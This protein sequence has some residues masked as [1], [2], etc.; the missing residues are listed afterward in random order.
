MELQ[1]GVVG[2]NGVVGELRGNQVGVDLR[3]IDR[4]PPRHRRV[5]PAPNV[6]QVSGR[7]VLLDHRSTR[8]PASSPGRRVDRHEL[9]VAE[10]RVLREELGRLDLPIC[11]HNGIKYTRII[12]YQQQALIN[13]RPKRHF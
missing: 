1:R 11:T 9:L 7:R 3:A 5:E 13:L 6:E 4:Y 2:H 10:D 8:L 12:A